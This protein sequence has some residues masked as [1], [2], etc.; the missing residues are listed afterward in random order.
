MFS[1]QQQK[2]TKAPLK[3][4]APSLIST[5]MI[6]HGNIVTEGE[7]QIDGKITGDVIAAKLTLGVEGEI[8]GEVNAKSVLIRGLVK[9]RL[10][11]DKVHLAKTADV[12]GDICHVTLT[13]DSGAILEGHCKHSENPR[14]LVGLNQPV[15]V[16]SK[17]RPK[18]APDSG[19]TESQSAAGN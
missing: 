9:G 14:E 8:V 5:D 18:S 4:V 15:L 11:A 10:L 2:K 17:S 3:A 7:V 12:K 1:K 19:A 16:T 13:I 6:F